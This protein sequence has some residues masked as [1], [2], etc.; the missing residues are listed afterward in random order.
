MYTIKTAIYSIKTVLYTILDMVLK[1]C[2]WR[3]LTFECLAAT[4]H[5]RPCIP[6]SFPQNS[7]TF[8]G[9]CLQ[10]SPI[11]VRLFCKNKAD[12]RVLGGNDE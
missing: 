8:R 6:R 10:K 12:S 7:P 4:I 2:I 11:L 9:A 5:R 1:M 3:K